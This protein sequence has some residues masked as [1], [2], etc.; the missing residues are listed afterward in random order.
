[1]VANCQPGVLGRGCLTEAAESVWGK[2]LRQTSAEGLIFVLTRLY[3]YSVLLPCETATFQL[4]SPE[5]QKIGL[6]S[7]DL[8]KMLIGPKARR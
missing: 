2:L 8:H 1:M 4:R 7:P 5:K 6:H 3:F